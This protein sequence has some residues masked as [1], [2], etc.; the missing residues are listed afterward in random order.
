MLRGIGK[1]PPTAIQPRHTPPASQSSKH[2]VRH[3][4]L[5]GQLTPTRPP[6]PLPLPPEGKKLAASKPSIRNSKRTHRSDRVPQESQ[7][8]PKPRIRRLAPVPPE[9]KAKPLA[10][11]GTREGTASNLQVFGGL[12]RRCKVRSKDGLPAID[13]IGSLLEDK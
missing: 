6:R 9:P 4:V 2:A 8:D 10:I 3:P 13:K 1:A 11:E 5:L 7:I 12:M